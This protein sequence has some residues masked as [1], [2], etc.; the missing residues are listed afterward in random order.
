LERKRGEERAQAAGI[1]RSSETDMVYQIDIS[2]YFKIS[3]FLVQ[4]SASIST[5]PQELPLYR[6]R[7]SYRELYLEAA[8]VRAGTKENPHQALSIQLGGTTLGGLIEYFIN[9]INPNL[10][11]V[12]EAPWNLLNAVE[13]SRLELLVDP[14]ERTIRVLYH[15]DL[16]LK[17]VT[18][19]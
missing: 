19:A 14:T 13:L 9:L 16:D 10:H 2:G 5:S 15:L 12:L 3:S 11:Y 7:I 17:F 1:I 18:T 8:V 6:F 4:V